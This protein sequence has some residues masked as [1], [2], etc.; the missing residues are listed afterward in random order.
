MHN[1][2][3]FGRWRP[4]LRRQPPGVTDVCLTFDDG[5]SPATT[6]EVLCILARH[7]AKATFFMS[8]ARAADHPGLVADVVAEGHDVFGHGWDHEDLVAAGPERALDAMRRV[9]DVLARFR[10]TPSPYLI[11]LP[12]SAGYNQW[13]MHCAMARFHPDA[14]FAWCSLATNDHLLADGSNTLEEL[15]ARCGVVAKALGESGRLPGS[16]V[17][18]HENPI[19]ASGRLVPDIARVLLPLVLDEIAVRG[20]RAGLIRT[21]AREGLRGRFVFLGTRGNHEVWRPGRALPGSATSPV[22]P[23]ATRAIRWA[24]P[25]LPN[26]GR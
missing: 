7:G 21:A 17:L 24:W 1:P 18:L 15:K 26:G 22:P 3:S 11:R 19:G 5:P 25:V 4:V 10:P 2:L 23:V 6:P 12:F 13:R 20:L 9:E 8:G 14:R 16:I